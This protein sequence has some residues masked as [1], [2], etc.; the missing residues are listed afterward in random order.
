MITRF[1]K[2]IWEQAALNSVLI[3]IHPQNADSCL[4]AA[5]TQTKPANLGCK[6]AIRQL[7]STFTITILLLLSPKVDTHF[8]E[9]T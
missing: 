4:V 2:V 6:S 8:T 1:S 3:H 9:S 7:P 5:N